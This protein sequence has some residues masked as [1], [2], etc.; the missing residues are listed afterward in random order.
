M[1]NDTLSQGARI[2]ILTSGG[3]APGMNAAVRAAVKMGCVRGYRMMGVAHGFRGLIDGQL[4]AL[5][6]ADVEGIERFGG[7]V[8]GSARALDFLTSDGQRA[9][10]ARVRASRDEAIKKLRELAEGL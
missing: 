1:A 2:G 5:G 4:R 7:T 9:A 8:L 3:D 10:E 6:S